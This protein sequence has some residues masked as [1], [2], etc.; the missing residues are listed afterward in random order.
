MKP[1]RMLVVTDLEGTPGM[2]NWDRYIP[3]DEREQVVD[4]HRR[5]LH[6]FCKSLLASGHIRIVVVEGHKNTLNSD[7]LPDAVKL[8]KDPRLNALKLP[9]DNTWGLALFGAHGK[10]GET[11]P[12]AHTFSSRKRQRWFIGEKEVGEV[13]VIS[14]WAGAKGISLLFVHGCESA[15]REGKEIFPGIA[16]VVS[17]RSNGTELDFESECVEI[18]RACNEIASAALTAKPWHVQLGT[19]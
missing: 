3:I 11:E 15:C 17:R 9:L 18:K 19:Q 12:L 10:E 13:G 8:I 6:V 1:L 7:S 14:A 2:K 5:A 4:R 16:T